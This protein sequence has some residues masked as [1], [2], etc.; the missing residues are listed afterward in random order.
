[1]DKYDIPFLFNDI[2][3][4]M[5][6]HSEF[7]FRIP[8]IFSRGLP[9]N[10]MKE[11]HEVDNK[12]LNTHLADIEEA[13][14]Y[15]LLSESF[16]NYFINQQKEY[17]FQ[18][19]IL[20]HDG[21]FNEFGDIK[22]THYLF[23]QPFMSGGFPSM[24]RVPPPVPCTHG[25]DS[26]TGSTANSVAGWNQQNHGTSHSI[27][28]NTCF[29]QLAFN[30]ATASG[31]MVIGLYD[32]NGNDSGNSAGNLLVSTGTHAVSSGFNW[33]SITETTCPDAIA[34]VVE[35]S[36]SISLSLYY[37][38]S[39]GT[40]LGLNPVTYPTLTD[41]MSGAN[42]LSNYITNNKMGHT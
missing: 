19:G 5:P 7:S 28:K 33:K 42:Y 6:V 23:Q 39:G 8:D 34:W 41:P 4:K 26:V 40:R 30:V 29:D 32:N 24:N 10:I 35:N 3:N 18:S 36:D 25:A 22:G 21:F 37:A 14:H 15:K 1:M 20:N 31:N 27:T 17:H 11:S 38:T 12:F 13:S 2:Y 9:K 16:V